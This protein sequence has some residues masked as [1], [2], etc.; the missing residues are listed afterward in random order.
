MVIRRRVLAEEPCCYLCGRAGQANDVID[1]VRELADGGTDE[2][3][4]LRRCC[5][6]CHVAKIARESMRA[7]G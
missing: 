6:P 7:R 2:R 4:N 3:G 5:R 1:H